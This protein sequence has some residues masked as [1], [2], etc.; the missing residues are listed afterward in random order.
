M[1]N[2]EIFAREKFFDEWVEFYQKLF[3]LKLDPTEIFKRKLV[4]GDSKKIIIMANKLNL[5]KTAE[6][7]DHNF[8]CCRPGGDLDKLV[9]INDR[10]PKNGTYPI[11]V[12]YEAEPDKVYKNMSAEM[13][14]DKKVFG[15]TLLERMVFGL[16]YHLETGHHLDIDYWT[17]CSG[18]CW[19]DGSV[20]ITGNC[21]KIDLEIR[22]AEVDRVSSDLRA[23][24][25][26]LI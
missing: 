5:N 1:N 7:W 13:L 11:L 9:T 17:L 12:N 18:S 4:Y 25:V 26:S 24:K 10:D 19:K 14:W 8:S 2:K 15:I 16:K 23:R 20:V 21:A 22:S 3:G 6:V